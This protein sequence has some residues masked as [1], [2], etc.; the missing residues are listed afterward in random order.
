MLKVIQLKEDKANKKIKEDEYK[1]KLAEYRGS[2]TAPIVV[3][4]ATD[5]STY[6][7]LVDILDEMQICNIARYAIVNVTPYDLGLID[8]KTG[9]ATAQ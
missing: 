9:T 7:N 8:K 6:E 5:E 1:A 2:K 4:K 3:I